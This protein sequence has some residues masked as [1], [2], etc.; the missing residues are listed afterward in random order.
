MVTV[1]EVYFQH[2]KQVFM[3]FSPW[4]LASN[5]KEAKGK[6]INWLTLSQEENIKEYDIT[7]IIL[8]GTIDYV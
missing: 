5:I 6:A 3:K 2:R 1:Y 7:Q 4:V 8:R